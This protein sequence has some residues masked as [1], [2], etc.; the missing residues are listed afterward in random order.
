MDST[1]Q[2]HWSNLHSDDGNARYAALMTLLALTEQPVGWAYEV[3]DELLAKL[4]HPDNHQRA[5]AVQL[6]ANLAKSDPEQRMLHDVDALFAVT[7]DE[8]FVTARHSLQAVWKIALA[9][10]E[11]RRLVIERL[12]DRFRDCA[13]EKNS[14]LIRSDIIEG[15]RKVY[16]AVGSEQVRET[17]LALIE[18]EADAKY[19]KKY[20]SV[21]RSGR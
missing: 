21:W 13:S 11:H 7:R 2:A 9:G 15:L 17:A 14:T 16:D 19:R 4:R 5:I 12:A 10:E 1:T 8:R 18:T 6:L 20:S 3:W